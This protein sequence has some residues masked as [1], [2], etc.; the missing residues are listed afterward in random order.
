MALSQYL[1]I[2]HSLSP[3]TATCNRHKAIVT[4]CPWLTAFC[5]MT[6]LILPHSGVYKDTCWA[7][8]FWTSKVAHVTAMVFMFIVNVI[9]PMSI[10]I[11]TFVMM[12]RQ[13]KL[14]NTGSVMS[15]MNS[16][17]QSQ[18]SF[19]KA[20]QQMLHILLLL[21]IV[22]VICVLPGNSVILLVT[23]DALPNHF[24]TRPVFHICS[25]LLFAS[26]FFN[27]FIYGF[28]YKPFRKGFRKLLHF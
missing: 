11:Y 9:I 10:F 3:L 13:L 15:Q 5:Y 8:A 28:R 21:C 2:V 16:N 6:P 7:I 19:H 4:M 24:M 12:T 25:I 14:R 23:L 1:L 18:Y 20:R 27:P 26:C 17:D 22:Y